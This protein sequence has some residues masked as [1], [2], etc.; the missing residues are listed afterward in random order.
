MSATKIEWTGM[1]WNVVTGCTK[2]S[3]GCK[4]CYM[5]REYPRLTA[6][7]VDGY[8]RYPEDIVLHPGRLQQPQHWRK[9]R[10]VFVNSMSDT[11]H[12]RIPDHFLRWLFQAMLE[13]TSR[14]YTFQ[15]LTKRPERALEWWESY[16][17]EDLG[18]VWPERVW[19]GVSVESQDYADQRLN[20]LSRIPAPIRFVSAEPLLGP[21]DLG[22]WLGDVVEW[23]IVGGES[24]PGAR[25]MRQEWALDLLEQCDAASVPAFLKQLGGRRDKRGGDQAVINGQRWQRMPAW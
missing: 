1:T 8:Q 16:G 14:G 15:V 3:P 7:G 9:P 18:G 12:E 22:Q 4:H 21:L 24:G 11:F 19:L 6:M 25:P 17:A 2:V 20:P 10:L 13:A 5:Y 23:V